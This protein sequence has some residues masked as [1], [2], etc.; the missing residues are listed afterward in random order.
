ME[1]EGE[2]EQSVR[3]GE[4]L[5]FGEK[6]EFENAWYT[7]TV[8][9]YIVDNVVNFQHIFSI[10][11]L[12]RKKTRVIYLTQMSEFFSVISLSGWL[13][14]NLYLRNLDAITGQKPRIV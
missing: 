10:T 14:R 8:Y 1:E 9:M 11:S 6:K 2:R 7:W 12:F 4:R 5:L 13:L 3:K